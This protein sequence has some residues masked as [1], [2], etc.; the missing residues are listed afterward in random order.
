MELNL[1]QIKDYL[2]SNKENQDVLGVVKQY[3]PKQEIG[4]EDVQKLVNEKEDFKKW[5]DSEKDKHFSKGLDTWKQKSL[6]SV[7]DEEIKKRFPEK[8]P[9]DLENESLR[10]ELENFKKEILLKD[11]KA[12]ALTIASE[13]KIPSKIID[14]FIGQDEEST[15]SNLS[16]FEEVMESYVKAQVDERLNNT[17]QPP[18]GGGNP[19]V[20][21]KEKFQSMGYQERVQLKE[22]NPELYEQLSK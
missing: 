16:V 17:H 21:T 11:L 15:V 5:I 14:F 12:K 8:D 3:A 20:I 10:T 13:K 9:K 6:P 22:D 19:S 4:L 1:D 18:S 2:E 7:L